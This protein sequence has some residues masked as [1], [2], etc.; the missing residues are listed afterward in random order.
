MENLI[1]AWIIRSEKYYRLAGKTQNEVKGE[2]LLAIAETYNLCADE[3]KRA[4]AKEEKI[5]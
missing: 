3:L 5:K 1:K 2:C 4:I